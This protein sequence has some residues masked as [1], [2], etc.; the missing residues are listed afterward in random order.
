MDINHNDSGKHEVF[1]RF[2]RRGGKIIYP[3]HARYFHFWVED[4]PDVAAPDQEPSIDRSMD[5]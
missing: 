1:C 4:H 5:E 3:K 2:I